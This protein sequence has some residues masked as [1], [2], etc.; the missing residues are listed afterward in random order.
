LKCQAGAAERSEEEK[1]RMKQKRGPFQE[2]G[3]A[4][5]VALV[6]YQ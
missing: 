5:A 2:K 4:G 1:W 6:V 3:R